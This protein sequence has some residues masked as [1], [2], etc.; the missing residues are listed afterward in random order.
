M[1]GNQGVQG[2]IGIQG[3]DGNQG[4]FDNSG[5]WSLVLEAS[6]FTS[7][8][9][10]TLVVNTPTAI[11][12]TTLSL[13]SYF[14]NPVQGLSI[15]DNTAFVFTLPGYYQFDVEMN[16]TT[17]LQTQKSLFF[18]TSYYGA[19]SITD[20]NSSFGQKTARFN[21]IFSTSY[22]FDFS[23]LESDV[24]VILYVINDYVS[25]TTSQTCTIT[26]TWYE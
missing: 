10:T 4:I 5:K 21:G 12:F 11:N 14:V 9:S 15:I 13:T 3:L 6:Q 19:T 23:N 2:L 22:M 20:E 17:R 24:T 7:S 8:I 26:R 18:F 1:G 16:L 25:T